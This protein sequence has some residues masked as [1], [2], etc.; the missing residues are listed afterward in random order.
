MY[1]G[2]ESHC[3]IVPMNSSN[4]GGRSP[5]EKREGRLRHKEKPHMPSTHPTQCGAR[6]SQGLVGVRPFGRSHPSEEPYALTS[7][8]TDLCGLCLEAYEVQSPEMETAAKSSQQ[9]RTE[10]CVMT[11]NGHCEA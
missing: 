4:K 7:A 5:A 6:V 2:E 11:G 9:P 1:A 10:S 8:R 3:G